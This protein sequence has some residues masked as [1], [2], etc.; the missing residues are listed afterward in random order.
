MKNYQNYIAEIKE[1]KKMNLNPKPIENAELLSEIIMQ[2]KDVNNLHRKESINFFTY[3]TIPGTTSAAE[4]KA[5]FLKEIILN[6]AFV[7]EI[8]SDFAFELLSHMKGGP[9]VRVLL[10]LALGDN[11]LIAKNAANILKT[12]VFLYD[13]DT[14]RLANAYK[15]KNKIAEEIIV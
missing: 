12:Q 5:K 11:L 13:A 6:E 10:D 7:E 9:S 8:S 15:N 1:R 14:E 3:N 2:I 4:E